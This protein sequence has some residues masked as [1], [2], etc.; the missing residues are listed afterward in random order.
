MWHPNIV[1]ETG[2]VCSALL[3]DD[4]SPIYTLQ[5]CLVVLQNVLND[6]VVSKPSEAANAEAALSLVDDF[7]TFDKKAR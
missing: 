3:Y 6:P 4:W 2:A 5:K 1:H 7:E